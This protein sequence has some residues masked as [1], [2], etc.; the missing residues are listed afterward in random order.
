MTPVNRSARLDSCGTFGRS[1]V[2]R[3]A[4]SRAMPRHPVGTTRRPE[5]PVTSIRFDADPHIAF[6][7]SVLYDTPD[8]FGTEPVRRDSAGFVYRP[9][10]RPRIEAR[11]RYPRLQTLGNPYRYGNRS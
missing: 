4:D 8:H 11:R 7:T 9:K 5:S 1:P 3:T 2:T 6:R 10:D